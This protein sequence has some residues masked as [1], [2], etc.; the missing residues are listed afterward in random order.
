MVL[1]QSHRKRF[2]APSPPGPLSG[3]RELIDEALLVV[4][5]RDNY[6]VR[7]PDPEHIFNLTHRHNLVLSIAN[8]HKNIIT[9]DLTQVQV[10]YV[11]GT[12]NNTRLDWAL[13]F[14]R[15]DNACTCQNIT[16]TE[17]IPLSSTV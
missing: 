4:I 5:T 6:P 14:L 16:Y 11:S 12:Q 2:T 9:N 3:K 8:S 7:S 10:F 13:T 15:Q 17:E 1:Q